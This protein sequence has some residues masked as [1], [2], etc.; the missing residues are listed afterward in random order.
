[1]NG[2]PVT[3]RTIDVGAD[4][5]LESMSGGD[6]YETAPNPALGL[7]AIRWSLS[8]PQMFMTQLRA[9]LRAS[10]F[11]PAK[12]LIPML[13]HAQEIDQTLDLIQEAKR[14]LDDAASLRQNVAGRR[15]DRDSSRGNRGAAVPEA[16]RFPVDRDQRPDPVHAGHRPRDNAVA[17]LYDPLHPAVLQPDRVHAARSESCGRAGFGVRRNGRR[18][19]A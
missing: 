11:G 8:E 2:R 16:A 15:D 14:Q 5:P 9:I 17:H 1:M 18:P 7:R 3:I 12:I 4:K 10:A 19:V 6:G 13:A